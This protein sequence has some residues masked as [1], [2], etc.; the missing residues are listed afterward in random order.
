VMTILANLP[1][2]RMKIRGQERKMPEQI[3]NGENNLNNRLWTCN[4]GGEVDFQGME[5][6]TKEVSTCEFR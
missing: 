2:L 6:A 5:F 1:Q 4:V 3:R